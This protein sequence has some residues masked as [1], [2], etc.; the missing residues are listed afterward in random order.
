MMP[1]K[2]N[3]YGVPAMRMLD[4]LTPIFSFATGNEP[5]S[6]GTSSKLILKASHFVLVIAFWCAICKTEI[7]MPD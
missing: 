7:N 6:I 3:S 5:Q 1:P 2:Q 4:K